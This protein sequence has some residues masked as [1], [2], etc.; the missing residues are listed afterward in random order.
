MHRE[1]SRPVPRDKVLFNIEMA[2]QKGEKLWPKRYR[3][4]DHDRFKPL[5]S[6]IL[7]HLE[8]CGLRFFRKPPAPGHSTPDPG[9]GYRSGPDG[10]TC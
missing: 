4:G 3:P 1:D 6:G 9:P 10:G 7:E 5:A 8:L 2:L